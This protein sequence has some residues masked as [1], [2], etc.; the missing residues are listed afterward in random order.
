MPPIVPNVNLP[1]TT[2]YKKNAPWVGLFVRPAQ[3]LPDDTSATTFSFDRRDYVQS[4]HVWTVPRLDPNWVAQAPGLPADWSVYTYLFNYNGAVYTA[5]DETSVL[6]EKTVER[7]SSEEEFYHWKVTCRYSSEV[8]DT[9]NNFTDNPT[10]NPCRIEWDSETYTSPFPVDLDGKPVLNSAFQP[11]TPTPTVEQGR[12][13][14]IITNVMWAGN[15]SA[16]VINYW[17]FVTNEDFFLSEGPGRW[18]ALPP[19]CEP[20]YVGRVLYFRITR[21]LRLAPTSVKKKTDGSFELTNLTWDQ[22]EILNQGVCRRQEDSTKEFYNQPVPI[23]R[24]TTPITQPV[25]L[26]SDGQPLAAKSL[27]FGALTGNTVVTQLSMEPTYEKFRFRRKIVFADMFKNY[28]GQYQIIPTNGAW[29]EGGANYDKPPNSS[30][31]TQYPIPV[32]VPS[33]V[34]SASYPPGLV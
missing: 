3:L 5:I 9:K 22:E 14:A 25:L 30:P 19:R 7:L 34:D 23:F 31:V 33:S 27:A 24:G 18:L 4:Y 8:P 12:A 28:Q 29:L 11:F 15:V 2:G 26:D 17:S 20:F 32:I 21:R 1:L 13:C 10:R 16:A 6:V